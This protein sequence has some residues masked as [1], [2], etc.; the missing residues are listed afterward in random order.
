MTREQFIEDYKL[1]EEQMRGLSKNED[2]AKVIDNNKEFFQFL[3]QAVLMRTDAGNFDMYYQPYMVN[4]KCVG[5]EA[6]FRIKIA[7]TFINP[8]IVFATARYFEFEDELTI[9]A[10]EVVAKDINILKNVDE[11]F[12]ATFNVNPSLL[13]SF[14]C[15]EILSVLY[16][17]KVDP[18]HLGIE[19][20]ECSSCKNVDVKNIEYLKSY[21]VK[22]LLDDYGVGYSNMDTLKSLPFDTV[23][24]DGMLIREI[25]NDPIKQRILSKVVDYCYQNNISTIAEQV[26]T[27]D[28]CR[29]V[30][31][32]G[33]DMVQGYYYSKPIT[34]DDLLNKYG[35]IE[36][37]LERE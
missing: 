21:G 15:N 30:K 37:A 32:I 19:L 18:K 14:Y 13:N 8:A 24:F 31:T 27:Y 17:H 16:K 35:K 33:V 29:M 26:E 10:L 28:E 12:V 20:L 11:N 1:I 6:L 9:R 22:F 4:E 25:E 23:K 2:M 36:C 34:A 7:D 5:A 3:A